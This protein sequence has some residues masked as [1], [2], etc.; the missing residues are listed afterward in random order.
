MARFAARGYGM[1]SV[2]DRD[3]GGFQGVAGL[4]DRADGRG[5]ALRFALWP[6]ARGAGLAREAASAVLSFGHDRAGL[7]RIVAVA[8]ESNFGSRMVLGSIGMTE[9]ERFERDGET[10]LT[11]ESVRPPP[12][13]PRRHR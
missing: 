5:T 13:E 3:D 11:Y 1:W 9:C 12:P 2:R 6:Q 4:M 7:S 10:M 8:R